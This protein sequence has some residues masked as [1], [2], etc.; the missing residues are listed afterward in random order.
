MSKKKKNIRRKKSNNLLKG[1]A[2]AG[3]VVG[4]GTIFAGNNAVYA[5]ENE[6]GVIHSEEQII[7]SQSVSESTTESLSQVKSETSSF[8]SEASAATSAV[9]GNTVQTNH[10]AFVKRAPRF[11]NNV[12][13]QSSDEQNIMLADETGNEKAVNENG[14]EQEAA[15]LSVSGSVSG[16]I[17]EVGSQ[18]SSE[19]IS[20]SEAESEMVSESLST[21]TSTEDFKSESESL[22]T[23]VST[24]A[25]LSTSAET[26]TYTSESESLSKEFTSTSDSFETQ[27]NQTLEDLITNINNAKRELEKI[28]QDA[29]KNNATL[30]E[31]YRKKADDLAKYLAQYNF[32]QKYG[33]GKVTEISTQ[34][35]NNGIKEDKNGNLI[36]YWNYER[37]NFFVKYQ[38]ADNKIYTGYFDWVA[39]TEK[40]DVYGNT[41]KDVKGNILY[42]Y[43][44]YWETNPLKVDQIMVIE[45]APIYSD[46]DWY[47]QGRK[48][49]YYEDSNG[50][51]HAYFSKE[52][53][54]YWDYSSGRYKH[55]PDFKEIE[56]FSKN[57][58]RSE[59]GSTIEF[60]Y[61]DEWYTFTVKKTSHGKHEY[62]YFG[63]VQDDLNIDGNNYKTIKGKSYFSIR[64]I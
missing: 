37:N 7:E 26:S 43:T 32:Y 9:E 40:K 45:K 8:E 15:S 47:N 29:I 57:D 12:Q 64:H 17:S 23:S 2:A 58:I 13:A 24:S 51:I 49:Y 39:V 59:N 48:F 5:A 14:A 20:G 61:K 41:L 28:R 22:S 55:K 1:M 54:T 46:D 25:S 30:G 18:I 56:S 38:T 4:G 34:Y 62:P 11:F 63:Q 10:K 35:N 6:Q 36:S 27:K 3:A 19:S 44:P 33:V 53:I 50:K 60:R 21:S 42:E 52:D 31:A 16:S